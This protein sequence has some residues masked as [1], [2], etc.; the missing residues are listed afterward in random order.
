MIAGVGKALLLRHDDC[1]TDQ[2]LLRAPPT[3]KC[4]QEGIN[5]LHANLHLIASFPVNLTAN[6]SVP[7]E[8]LPVRKHRLLFK[9]RGNSSL[10]AL[11]YRDMQRN[12]SDKGA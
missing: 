12:P 9:G 1:V 6:I 3:E 10:L 11:C 8:A 4:R 5:S 2:V 7:S